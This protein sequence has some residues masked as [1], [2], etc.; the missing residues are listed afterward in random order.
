MRNATAGHM[1]CRLPVA[2]PG[3][4]GF[5]SF[6]SGTLVDVSS[7]DYTFGVFY[8]AAVKRWVSTYNGAGYQYVSPDGLYLARLDIG[9]IYSPGGITRG[10]TTVSLVDVRSGRVRDAGRMNISARLIA[11]R[12]EGLYVIG[13]RAQPRLSGI[14]LYDL[15]D[16]SLKRLGPNGDGPDEGDLWF[17]LVDD[18]IWGG[19]IP[20]PD[21]PS[22]GVAKMSLRWGTVGEWLAAPQ[23][24]DAAIVGFVDSRPVIALFDPAPFGDGLRHATFEYLASPHQAQTIDVS[25]RD[26][27]AAYGALG[28]PNG[29][30]WPGQQSLWLYRPDLGPVKMASLPGWDSITVAG[31]C[32]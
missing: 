6:P 15:H 10:Y 21:Q 19:L 11:F 16:H 27:L 23:G 4:V 25:A 13:G 30:W 8:D 2:G 5:V 20:V 14:F 31:P 22:F 3:K 1:S 18:S 29:L 9:P 28:D 7:R 26:G 32:A 17:W 24:R 12:P